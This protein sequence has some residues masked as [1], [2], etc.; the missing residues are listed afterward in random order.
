M[1]RSISAQSFKRVSQ[2]TCV[3][4]REIRDKREMVRLVRASDNSVQ[5]DVSGKKPGRG[6][7]LCRTRECWEIGLRGSQLEHALRTTLIKNNRE[8]LISYAKGLP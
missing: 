3:A 2:R 4:C 6:A 5:V 1:R 8:Q 7:Y